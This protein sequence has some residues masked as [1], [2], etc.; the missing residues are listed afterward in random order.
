MVPLPAGNGKLQHQEKLLGWAL[1][2]LPAGLGGTKKTFG[3]FGVFDG[4]Q[5]AGFN[6]KKKLLGWAMVPLPAGNGKLQHQEKLLGWALVPLPAGL[7]GT[8]KTFGGFGVF[9][10]WQTAGFNAKKKLLGWAL[11]P[12]QTASTPR[13]IVAVASTER[14]QF[15]TSGGPRRRLCLGKGRG[16][17]IYIYM[18]I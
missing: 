17:R 5:T 1:V 8:K 14:A 9:D 11:V 3:G 10:G 2:P 15:H 18:I 4:W 7:G 16:R 12:L 6:A 13:A